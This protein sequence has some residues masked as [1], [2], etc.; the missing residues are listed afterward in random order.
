ML[1]FDFLEWDGCDLLLASIFL[2]CF[3]GKEPDGVDKGLVG[4]YSCVDVCVWTGLVDVW[5]T[6]GGIGGLGEG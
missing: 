1:S 4:S 6:P 2:F 3:G 5:T